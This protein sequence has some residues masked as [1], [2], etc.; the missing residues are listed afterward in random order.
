ML[1]LNNDKAVCMIAFRSLP[2]DVN[3]LKIA[4]AL[5]REGY[6]I[7]FFCIKSDQEDNYE[8]ILGIKIHRISV[9]N[10]KNSDYSSLLLYYLLFMA[11]IFFKIIKLARSRRYYLYHIHNPPDFLLFAV[12]PLK[13]LYSAKFVLDLHDMLPESVS[14]NLQVN[15]NHILVR[16]S[17]I[18]ERIC[19]S[20]SDAIICTNKYDKE[21]VCSRNN[22]DVRKV[23]VVMN[24]PDFDLFK[25]DNISKRDDSL[26]NK[27]IILYQGTIWQ[28]RGIQTVINA[29][30]LMPNNINI[31]FYVIG[32]G[33]YLEKLKAVVD[34]RHLGS[35]VKFTGWIDP[36]SLYNYISISDVCII[37]FLKNKVNDRGVPN[38]LFEYI[39]QEKPVIVSKLTG[40]S[41][42]FNDE[43]VIFFEPGNAKDLCD[44]LIW[45]HNNIDRLNY[46]VKNAKNKYIKKYTWYKMKIELYKCYSSLS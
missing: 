24:T 10:I 32:D 28:R 8:N 3:R 1:G 39:A 11:K 5:A 2:S 27:F 21:I 12:I 30:D 34:T 36:V 14:S 22:I 18:I 35:K 42:I 33:P 37:P 13:L 31:L 40:M 38:K 20:F 45:C 6:D 29:L 26:S 15:D 44:K 41:L 43:E 17:K 16:F 23:F 4:A 46:F 19:I 7:D 9:G 25:I